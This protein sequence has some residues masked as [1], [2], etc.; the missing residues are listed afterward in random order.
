LEM[1]LL[2]YFIHNKIYDEHYYEPKSWDAKGGGFSHWLPK[3]E[4]DIILCRVKLLGGRIP[5]AKELGWVVIGFGPKF[6]N[7]PKPWALLII[8]HE[9]KVIMNLNIQ[10]KERTWSKIYHEFKH[11]TKVLISTP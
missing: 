1:L 2:M 5:K 3:N 7:V 6:G 11:M 9:T 10:Q 4:R 8:K